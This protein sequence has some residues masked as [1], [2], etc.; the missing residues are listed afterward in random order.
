MI[1]S[2]RRIGAVFLRYFYTIAGLHQISDLFFWPLV[3]IFLWGL[4]TIWLQ[5]QQH[6]PCT[7]RP[8]LR[9]AT[10][11]TCSSLPPNDSGSTA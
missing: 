4:T 7:P 5:Q 6:A 1:F 10:P 9:A 11:H 3:D 2:L 8:N